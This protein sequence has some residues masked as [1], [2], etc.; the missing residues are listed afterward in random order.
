MVAFPAA[1]AVTNPAV[2][3]VATAKFPLFQV[4]V[5]VTLAVLP[6]L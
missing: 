4:A 3:T 5:E 6:S 1:I 2:F